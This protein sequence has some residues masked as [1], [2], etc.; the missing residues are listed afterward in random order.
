MHQLQL[1]T[2]LACAVALAALISTAAPSAASAAP[3]PPGGILAPPPGPIKPPPPPAAPLAQPLTATRLD[4]TIHWQDR[5]TNEQKFVVYKRDVRGAWRFYYE[6]ATNH[7][8]GVSDEY[9]ITDIDHS[10]S[11]QCYMIESLGVTGT[12]ASQEV[13][14]VRPDPS[15]FPQ[16]PPTATK[17]WH[18]LSSINDGTGNLA[19]NARPSDNAE[20]TYANQTWGLDLDWAEW[21]ALWK[22]EAQGGPQLMHGQAVA[23]RVWGGGWLKYADDV[24]GTNLT[25]SDTPSYEWYVLTANV[26][27][28]LAGGPFALWNSA[29]RDYLVASDSIFGVSLEWY[30]NTQHDPPPSPTPQQGVKTVAL[31][32]CIS[33]ARPLEMWVSD[34][35]AGGGWTDK[36]Q[37]D[38]QWSGSCPAS[39]T[40]WTFSPPVS[41]HVYQVRS[42][43]FLAPGCDNDPTDG[44]CWRSTTPPFV[45]DT[46]GQ[47]AVF[48]IG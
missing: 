8:A 24:H 39:A 28:P 16:A 36:G 18:G 35:S 25:F 46:N 10:V 9:L 47:V 7:M 12:A 41:G 45:S 20:L 37:L 29:V 14:T 40:P 27:T 4:V 43:D 5:S 34:L 38:S 48:T 33:E 19:S 11:G 13:C 15:R 17:Q 30:E 2:V 32:N 23:L 44:G 1:H 42:V 31:Y 6:V 21:P 22:V 3:R 26:G